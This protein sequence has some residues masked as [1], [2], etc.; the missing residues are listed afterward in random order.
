MEIISYNI[1][2]HAPGLYSYEYSTMVT[3]P[4]G[5]FFNLRHSRP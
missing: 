5:H 4:I 3:A 1:R 2:H